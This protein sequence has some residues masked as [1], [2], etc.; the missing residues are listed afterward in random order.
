[1]YK[2]QVWWPPSGFDVAALLVRAREWGVGIQPVADFCRR[3]SWP[4]GVV[5]GYSARQDADLD[6][7]EALLRE[8]TRR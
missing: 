7:L 8:V 5:I 3:V 6:R 4:D 2:R 1:M